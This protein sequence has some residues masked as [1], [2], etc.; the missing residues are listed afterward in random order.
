MLSNRFRGTL[1]SYTDHSVQRRFKSNTPNYGVFIYTNSA[2]QCVIGL[3]NITKI[4][5]FCGADG[6]ECVILVLT[7]STWVRIRLLD[8]VFSPFKFQI[9]SENVFLIKMK[10]IIK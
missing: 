10:E 7:R 9:T 5:S 6:K 8:N 1:M 4:V 3:V 2:H